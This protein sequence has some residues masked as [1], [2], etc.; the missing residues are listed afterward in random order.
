M[1]LRSCWKSRHKSSWRAACRRI[2]PGLAALLW[3]CVTHFT[4][5]VGAVGLTK[6]VIQKD[7]EFDVTYNDTVTSENQTIYAFNHTISRNR[8][9]LQRQPGYVPS[10]CSES[11]Q[12]FVL[13]LSFFQTDGVRV[14]VDVLSQG[15]DSPV[16]FAVRQ[17][18]AV[19]SFQVPLIL[20]GL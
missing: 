18:Q 6:N 17:K 8:V 3:L 7:A 19:L 5:G 11:A 4:C 15:F 2:R 16:L 14:T 20:R 10:Q 1:V 9:S 12:E 13:S